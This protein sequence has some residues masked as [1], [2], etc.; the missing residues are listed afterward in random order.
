MEPVR[1]LSSSLRRASGVRF[2][3]ISLDGHVTGSRIRADDWLVAK[4]LIGS[5]DGSMAEAIARLSGSRPFIRSRAAFPGRAHRSSGL[6]LDWWGPFS[7]IQFL[8]TSRQRIRPAVRRERMS[9]VSLSRAMPFPG[10]SL[11]TRTNAAIASS[12]RPPST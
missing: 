4:A 11:R 8:E 12:S 7:E 2:D 1:F 3:D 10:F 5:E 9:S 6:E